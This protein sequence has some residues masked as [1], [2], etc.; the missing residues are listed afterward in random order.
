MAEEK[1]PGD[2]GTA[3]KLF[4]D[5]FGKDLESRLRAVNV[6]AK[7]VGWA[8]N[9][10]KMLDRVLSPIRTY[11]GVACGRRE[12]VVATEGR[13]SSCHGSERRTRREGG[14]GIR[15]YVCG[16]TN[17]GPVDGAPYTRV[18]CPLVSPTSASPS[19]LPPPPSCPCV[20]C[21]P[22]SPLLAVRLLAASSS[23][24]A[25]RNPCLNT[26]TTRSLL[27]PP[28]AP[29]SLDTYT[30]P[31]AHTPLPHSHLSIHPYTTTLRRPSRRPV[32]V[33][34]AE[35]VGAGGRPGRGGG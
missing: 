18:S 30:L 8:I 7:I 17:V 10:A 6:L 27:E 24:L 35:R 33:A 19:L 29:P 1:C 13:Q 4:N 26:L 2:V 14:G 9:D 5:S 15:V 22:R 34:A 25:S 3:V 21:S 32:R 12:D 28:P 31:P 23:P 11:M 20:S 16:A